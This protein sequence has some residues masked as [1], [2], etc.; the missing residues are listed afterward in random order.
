MKR[1]KETPTL[2]RTRRQSSP[3]LHVLYGCWACTAL[4]HEEHEAHGSKSPPLSTKI[5]ALPVLRELRDLE[6]RTY[7]EEREGF[8]G[9]SDTASDTKNRSFAF[10][11]R[12]SSWH[13]SRLHG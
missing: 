2:L 4:H 3:L 9:N 6:A 8:E 7:H 10:L 5:E 1:L 13:S 12:A 11:L